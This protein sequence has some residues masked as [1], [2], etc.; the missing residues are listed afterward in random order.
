M[1]PYFTI[2]I[3]LLVVFISAGFIGNDSKKII[4]TPI[5]FIV[6]QGWP[7]PAYDF[8]NN[9]LTQEGFALGR[10]LFYDGRLSKDGNF[11][12]ASCHQQFGA[13]ATYDH[14]LS[15]GYNNSLTSRNAPALINMAWQKE[16]MW[17]GGI[18]HLDLQPLAPMTAPNE[19]AETLDSI[20]FKLNKDAVYKN[21]F[22]AAFGSE[23][24]NTKRMNKALSQFIVMIVSSNS[25]YDSVQRGQV[26]FTLSQQLGYNIFKQKCAACH[27]EPLFTDLSYRNIGLA[28]DPVLKDSGRMHITGKASDSLKF[29][30]PSLRNVMLTFPYGH[31]G[32][33]FSLFEVFD[34]YRN[35]V[36]NGPTTDSLVKN[37]LPLSNFEVGQLTSFLYTL[38]DSSV[39]KDKRFSP[40]GFDKV[41][42][43]PTTHEHNFK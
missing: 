35:K 14:N 9:P 30:V 13:F 43:R 4:G 1:K 7:Q 12:C 29:K 17:D 41:L 15:H 6:P 27:A 24:I 36:I 33:F 20:I 18:N 21:M 8:K 39:L 26:K 31:D 2:I 10:K 22:K 25:L 11:S 34:H 28:V 42:Q 23:L 3:L 16:F 37:K 38:T 5:K 32:R 40:P 19:M